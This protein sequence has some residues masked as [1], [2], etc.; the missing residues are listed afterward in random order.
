MASLIV[1]ALTISLAFNI[2]TSQSNV[3]RGSSLSPNGATNAWLSPSG[4]YAFGFYP[5]KDGYALGVYI[6]QTPQ[7]N[8]VW[9]ASRDNLPLP[10]TATLRF[11]TNGRLVL[12]QTQ[13][14]E[15][16]IFYD[17]VASF[18]SM[19]DS[20]NFVLYDSQGTV[21][22]QT[23][24]N[25][26]DTLLAGQRLVAGKTLFSG[27]SEVDQSIGV[28]KLAMQLDGH[29][30]QY[31]NVGTPDGPGP[32]YWASGT[33]GTGPNVT[34]NL[35]SDGFLYLL[36]NSTKLIRN[37]TQGGYPENN[38]IY[39]MKLDVDGI[40][41]LYSHD[42]SNMS[43]NGSVVWASF[44][45]KCAGKGLC[46]VNGYCEVMNDDAR[47]QCLPGFE[48]VNKELWSLGCQR[49]YTLEKCKMNDLGTAVRMESLSNAR[50][51]E[52]TYEIPE[53]TTTQEECSVSCLNDCNCEV[54]LF[55]GQECRF[56]RLPL[57][58]MEVTD[59]VLIYKA[60]V[61]AYRKVSDN[62]NFQLFEN[63]GPRAFSY[64]ELE[65]LTDGFK[66]ELGRG[67][68][69]IVYKGIIESSMK[70]VAVKKLKE[71]LAQQR[72]IEFQT[73][74]K[75]IGRTHHRN[76]AKLLG[77]CCEG[78]ERLLVFEY[79]PQG[80]LAD[81]LFEPIRNTPSWAERIR[82]AIDIAHGILYL[83]EECET[84]IIHC[85]IK[86][87]NILMGEYNCAKISD[88]G[89][90]KLLEHDQTRTSTLIRGTRGYVAPEW[91]KNLPITV[92]VDVY[93]FG[94]VLFEVLC[95]RR[96]V[97]NN[98]P[99]NEA[100][101]EE[102]V[103]DCFEADELSKL[104][105]GE[106]VDKRTLDRMV[107][108]GLWCIQEDPALRPSMKQVVLM[109]EG[110]VKIPVP[111]NPAS[112]LKAF[113]CL[114]GL[115]CHYTLDE[116]T[117]PRFV[118]KDGEDMDL[119][120]FIHALD[121]TKVRVFKRER[122][123]DEPR[124]LDTTASCTVPLL[125]VAPDSADSELKASV[126]RLFDEGGSGNRARRFRQRKFVAVDAGGASHTP[127]KLREDHGT[128]SGTFVAASVSTAQEREDEDHTKSVAEPNLRTIGVLQRF[129]ISSDSSHH[130]GPT[131][132]EAEVDP[133]VRSYIPVMTTATTITSMVDS[134]LVSREK[135]VKP[136]LFAADSSSASGVDPHTG[137]FSDLSGSD[138]LVSG[139]RTVLDLDID[140]QKVY[141]PQWSVT[142]KSRLDD[143]RVCHEMVDEFAPPKFFASFRR[144]EHDQL[145]TEFNVGAARQMS[146][147]AKVR[148]RAEYNVKERRRLKSV[149]E[150]QDEL[151]KAKDGE[152]KNLKAQLLLKEAE[153]AEAIRLR[154]EASNLE[155]VEK[156]CRNEVNALKE[157][158]TN[159][160]KERNALDVKAADL[161]AS[162]MDKARELTNLNVQLTI[163]KSQNDILV[164]QVHELEV[165]SV[166]LQEKLSS[167]ENLTKRLEEFQ[168]A[169]LRIVNDKF[170][171]LYADFVEMALHL[172]E[173]F[174][175]HILTTI[176]DR[177]LLLTHGMELA[178][179][180]CL[181]SP[182][183]LFALGAAV[184]KAIEKGMQDG[185]STWI[186]HGKEGKA[187]TNVAAHNPSAEAD[188]ISALQQLQSVN[189]SLL[190]KLKSNKDDSI[191]TVMD[192]LHLEDPLA[193][194]LRFTELQPHVD[195]L[196][197]P[198]HYSPD[199]VVVGAFALSLAL[200]ISSVR[201]QKIKENIV[202]HRSALRD[203]FVPLAE[204]FFVVVLIGLEGTSETIPTTAK[205]TM[206]LS[207]TLTSAS[208]I[209]PI[210]VDDYEV[211]GMD[212]QAS[213]DGNAEPFLNVVDAELNIPH[214]GM[215]ISAGMTASVP[216]VNENEV[217]LLLDFIMVRLRF[218]L[219][220]KPMV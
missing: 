141:F 105:D 103:Y 102:W 201:V 33:A 37:L 46:G 16:N 84:A 197:V 181:H 184:G 32:S 110:T 152:V 101:L 187:L 96:S 202:N 156:F 41:R 170:D 185:L 198:I 73:E 130:S 85:D 166:G 24:E 211:I 8:V 137:V 147:S 186:I 160:E 220:T 72:E 189:F 176:S 151:L 7:R 88:F 53:A 12:D 192:I 203:V 70:V 214:V 133:L 216:Y 9:T 204:P 15:I 200:D 45:N 75:V 209:A 1:F 155:A 193:E 121:P 80:S 178:L 143:G 120:D 56:Q 99:V 40:F 6:A 161:E 10:N 39:R 61:W 3:T 77:Y 210:F 19:Q 68:F 36:Q 35:D 162:A 78:S 106:D 43:K 34:L 129:V 62:I 30:V 205:T 195:Q 115:S 52:A 114:V 23:F 190:S 95:C 116:D 66:E 206:A 168:D 59:R 171:K 127:K 2:A 89:L 4:L 100:I 13:G 164:D 149:V 49:N 208:T 93:S 159:L 119:F 29:L 179:V 69:G 136:S 38:T 218:A 64:D 5:Q 183:Y 44:N 180:N 98:F 22:W 55:T 173:K 146:L 90:A 144:M 150:K 48:F 42:L 194:K 140:L 191:E 58:F 196:M 14:Q 27:I 60:R 131:I 172:K 26:T 135:T 107:K 177:R 138:F 165:S 108:I 51:E 20:G 47:C 109:L 139:I 122:E 91:Y 148:M 157:R 132:A 118:H 123:V 63:V 50:W 17:G 65:R 145:F 113:M 217:S 25:P 215:S 76:L 134:T 71:E 104:V 86:P 188:Y 207:T 153:A 81:I 21:L 212:E 92:K 158:N 111:P 219:F 124:L 167:Y 79:M 126:E 67:S 163:V 182:E 11:T 28:F 18:A 174:Y 97:E 128:S 83:H 213:A 125:P 169:Q 142:N 31:P 57:R 82:M 87:Q 199:K 54:A 94:I 112:F 175:P 117:Y 74:M 154:A